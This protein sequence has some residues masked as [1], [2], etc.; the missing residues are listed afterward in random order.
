MSHAARS[1]PPTETRPP[2]GSASRSS[3][4]ATVLLP[5]P[6]G[7]TSATVSPGRSSR[8]RPS[9]TARRARD[10]RTTRSRAGPRRRGARA[11]ARVAGAAAGGASSSVEQPV[12]DGEPVR[13]RV[14]LRA[15][16]AQRQ[17]QLGREHEHRERRPR[18]PIPPSTSRTPTVTATSATPSVAASSSTAPERN[19]TRS[20]PIV[21]R[22]YR[23]LDSAI[24]SA[25]AA[26]RL[27]ARSVGRPRTTSRKCVDEQ[28]QRLPALARLLLRIAAD[29]PH[30]HGYERQREQHDE[31]GD[32]V[33]RAD[34]HEHGDRDDAGQDD[35]RQ[36]AAE[37]APRDASTPWTAMVA[38][39]ALSAPSSADRLVAQ[40]P[41]D[42]R[43]GA[44]ARASSAAARRPATSKPQA[45]RPR[46][47]KASDEQHEST[48]TSSSDAPPNER[49]TMRA[50]SVAWTRTSTPRARRA[51]T[52]TASSDRAARARRSRRGSSA[53]TLRL[54]R[55]GAG[56]R[57]RGA[58]TVARG[59]SCASTSPSRAG[60]GRRS[61]S[62]PGRAARSASRSSA[63]TVITVSV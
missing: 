2:V 27:N 33:D 14:V 37:V 53:R 60:H 29:Q 8:S 10:T 51:A 62:S 30:E 49:A 61:T 34:P 12:G 48:E 52:S 17:V 57:P 6:L 22:R 50:S 3:S 54:A 20:V 35:L 63:T 32:R 44:A 5:R 55:P 31:R 39:S 23:S 26:P 4:A 46:A 13:A 36:V 40:P 41:L 19:A 24:A 25:C 47:A 43:R 58:S 59:A 56:R 18:S 28:P 45:R 15:E 7:P 9:S 38:S 11:A 16:R 42:E 1:A 21:A